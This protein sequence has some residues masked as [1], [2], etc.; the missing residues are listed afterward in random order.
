MAVT[1]AYATAA[2][3]RS[4][5]TKTDAGE[6]SEVLADLTAISR[7]LERRTG[8]F[9]N[10]DASDVTRII[11]PGE[12]YPEPSGGQTRL[13]IDD[14]SADPTSIKIDEDDDGLFTDET[15]LAS[16]DYILGPQNA[17]VGPEP[18]PYTHID[19]TRWGDKNT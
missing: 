8:R 10:V 18:S 7:F 12:G 17:D 19:L 4:V 6:D 14:L 1:D 13:Y 2:E 11:V 15:G 16:T 3:Y 5:I 9:F